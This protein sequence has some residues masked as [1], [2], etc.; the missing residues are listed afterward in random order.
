MAP[1]SGTGI[2]GVAVVVGGCPVQREKPGCPQRPASVPL[3]VVDA[4]SNARIATVN[5]GAD[6]TFRVALPPGRYVVEGTG[7]GPL[8]SRAVPVTVDVTA[9]HYASVTVQ[10]QARI[11]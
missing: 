5:S 6:G 9:G 11:P 1:N 3:A 10:F 7:T 2:V 4:A 8:M